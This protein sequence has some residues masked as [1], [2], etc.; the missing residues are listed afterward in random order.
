MSDQLVCR[1]GNFDWHIW[2]GDIECKKC[3]FR[4]SNIIEDGENLRDGLQKAIRY[5][6][7]NVLEIVLSE[8]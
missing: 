5:C 4:V 2:R 3:T 8:D 7:E 1:C 6:P